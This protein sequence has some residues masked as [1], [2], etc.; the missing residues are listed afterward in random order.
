MHTLIDQVNL[1]DLYLCT[2][3]EGQYGTPRNDTAWTLYFTSGKYPT[4]WE[5]FFHLLTDY[6]NLKYDPADKAKWFWFQCCQLVIGAE[7]KG[8]KDVD[9]MVPMIAID[10][11]KPGW[12]EARLR[13]TLQ[14]IRCI[15]HTTASSTEECPRWR[16]IAATDGTYFVHEHRALWQFM[17][18]L[19]DGEIDAKA[20]DASRI[21]Y[22]PAKWEGAYNVAPISLDG[23]PL[24]VAEIAALYPPPP[25]LQPCASANLI[26]TTGVEIIPN[27]MIERVR[28]LPKGGRMDDVLSAAA[29]R[30]K[31]LGFILT[32]DQLVAAALVVNS[33]IS[34]ND[35]RLGLH[36][37][38][39]RAIDWASS[40]VE[41]EELLPFNLFHK[42]KIT[43]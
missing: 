5:D 21:S 19:L 12:P 23:E 9:Y 20:K 8:L 43:A 26:L 4:G 13:A 17:Y 40:H 42:G 24:P 16:I 34:P 39:Q 3:G 7:T 10:I 1:N 27:Y 28:Y 36:R 15:I 37:K 38:A 32:A 33:I 25:P 29:A 6:A 18:D 11:D 14:G 30:F 35:K 31:R 22:M 41:T 2:A